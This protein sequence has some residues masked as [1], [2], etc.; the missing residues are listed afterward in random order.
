MMRDYISKISKD[1]VTVSEETSFLDRK[2]EEFDGESSQPFA[3]KVSVQKSD[4]LHAKST[5]YVLTSNNT[6][7]D[8]KG[9]DSHREKSLRLVLKKTDSK[10]YNSYVMYLKTNNNLHL[11]R[12]GRSYING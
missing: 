9:V 12:A 11:S 4:G 10:T 6:L 1:D 8:P 7:Y 3:K 2:G 5:Y